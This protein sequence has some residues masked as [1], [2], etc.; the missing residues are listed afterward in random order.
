MFNA[1]FY[2]LM[3]KNALKKDFLTLFHD[4]KWKNAA[5]E[6]LTYLMNFNAFYRI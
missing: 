6:I 1:F 2:D 4:H 5:D 3:P